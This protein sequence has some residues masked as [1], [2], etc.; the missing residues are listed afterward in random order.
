MLRTR[1]RWNGHRM[2]ADLDVAVDPA[3][4]VAQGHDAA[5]AVHRA[6]VESIP[7]LDRGRVHVEPVGSACGANLT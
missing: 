4:T 1:A 6:L 3:L 7:H 5:V 2:E